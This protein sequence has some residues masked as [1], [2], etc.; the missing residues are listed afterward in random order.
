[1]VKR[2]RPL[3]ILVTLGAVG[4]FGLALAVAVFV[5]MDEIPGV[6]LPQLYWVAAALALTGGLVGWGAARLW[7]RNDREE[8]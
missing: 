8:P 3:A 7:D 6:H 5:S 1:M 2:T 4:L